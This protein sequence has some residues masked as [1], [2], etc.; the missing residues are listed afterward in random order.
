MGAQSMERAYKTIQERRSRA[1]LLARQREEELAAALPEA[2]RLLQ[3]IARTGTRIAR[4][5]LSGGEG[6]RER[7]EAAARENL[8][9]QERL[10]QLLREH[11]YPA[12]YLD[13]PYTCGRC[14]DT[15]Y[16]GGRRCTCLTSLAARY[17]AEDFNAAAHI[18]PQTF[19]T[20]RLKYYEGAARKTMG[21]IL[22]SCRAYAEQFQPH[23]ASLLMMGETG[24][25]KT[26]LSLAIAARIM[27]RGFSAVYVSGPDLFRKLQNEYYG[28]GEPGADT[29]AVMLDTDLVILDDLGAEISGQ[30]NTSALYHLVNSRLNAGRATIISTNL[31]PRELESR[32]GARIASRLLTM[33]KCFC[34]VGRDI[35]Q[36]KL[37]QNE[38]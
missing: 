25:G 38:L 20:F 17:E 5:L 19:D 6:T 28:K 8:Q 15:G 10:E 22:D 1:E 35:R 24:L 14:R 21:E 27:E 34:F 16:D 26:H 12:D 32:Y 36:L 29:M 18:E 4:I 30:F 23:A 2:G 7:M 11:G 13:P 31:P 3:E 37:Q 33:Y 9:A